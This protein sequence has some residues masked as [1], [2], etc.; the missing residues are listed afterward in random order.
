MINLDAYNNNDA[1]FLIRNVDAKFRPI[2]ER[3]KYSENEKRAIYRYLF[4][5]RPKKLPPSLKSRLINLY[6]PL[7]DRSNKFPDGLRWCINVYVGCEN[8]CG[9]CYVNGYSQK[10]VG[11]F[12]HTKVKFEKNINDDL[13]A[14]KALGVP[15]APIHM[16]NSTDPL[17]ETLEKRNRHTLLSLKKISEHRNLFTSIVILTKNPKFL[18]SEPYLHII[19]NPEMSPFTVQVSCAYWNDEVRS[20]YEPKA[21]DIH[22]RLESIRFL[23]EH[24]ID[25]DLRIDPL[26]PS[27]R[28]P[29]KI[30]HHSPL[31][32]YSLPEAQSHKD[33]INLIRFAKN[34]NCKTV[35]S[36][37][38]KIPISKNSQICKD[39]FSAVYREASPN[40]KLTIA[41]ASWRLP[42]S[43]QKALISTISDICTEQGIRFKHC[44]HDVLTRE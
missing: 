14:L 22:S 4:S 44:M 11:I 38:L 16:S 23:S 37:T 13:H 42:G 3:K 31:P 17:Q 18:C 29:E 26:L 28:V 1:D 43:Y 25:V 12:P 6:D 32:H 9:Y 35:I 36:K 40:K 21:P 39:W 33:M 8:S 10:I 5:R 34:A 19:R 15:P 41:G 27:S 2:F 30:R 7:A 20:F 24:G